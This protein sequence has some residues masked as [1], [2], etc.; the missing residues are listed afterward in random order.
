MSSY[1]FIVIYLFLLT[2]KMLKNV[3]MSKKICFFA[4]SFIN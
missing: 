3:Y 2:N 4:L 1:L